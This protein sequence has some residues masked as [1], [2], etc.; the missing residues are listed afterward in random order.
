MLCG[1]LNMSLQTKE[2]PQSIKVAVVLSAGHLVPA[3]QGW[4][5]RFRNLG[6]P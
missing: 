3:D 1:L 6:S 2:N 4:N 5:D